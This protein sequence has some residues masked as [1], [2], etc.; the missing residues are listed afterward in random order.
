[1][2]LGLGFGVIALLVGLSPYINF[3]FKK[4]RA[5]SEYIETQQAQIASLIDEL[6]RR[7]AILKVLESRT[8]EIV[9]MEG[10]DV[11]PAGFGSIIWDPVK[12]VAILHVSNL[13]AVPEG[14]DYQLWVIKDQTPV[15]AG[16]FSV[17][18]NR[19]EESY[20][21]VQP[22]DVSDRRQVDAFA[23]TL[24][25]KGGVSRPTGEMYLLGKASA[26]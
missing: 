2:R 17:T 15:S 12:K 16:I 25:P 10:L 5:Q 6:D 20:F 3:Q 19:E 1:M 24:E 14:K 22:L 26:P 11:N 7:E 23:V 8:I 21:K 18:S 13:P 4:I 9:R